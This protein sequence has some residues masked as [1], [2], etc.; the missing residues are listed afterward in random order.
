MGM[1]RM[2]TLLADDAGFSLTELI[3]VVGLLPIVLA[4]AWGAL[5]YT[6]TSAAV[7]TTQGNAARD[8][9]NPMEQMSR[10][11]MQKMDLDTA[12]TNR[13]AVW[14]DRNMDGSPEKTAFYVTNDHKLVLERWG[15]N[16]ARTTVLSHSV[17]NMSQN[18]YNLSAGVPVFEYYDQSGTLIPEAEVS[19][20][21][22]SEAA[23]VRVRL[24]ID[25]GNSRTIQ[26]VRDITFRNGS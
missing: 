16:S 21:A 5:M 18:N 13:I 20:R 8:F 12:E 3:V 10:T 23:R 9:A 17:W 2:R 1:R 25:M 6:S 4:M 7:S 24:V 19:A 11:I 26:D 15:Y 14:T 22:G